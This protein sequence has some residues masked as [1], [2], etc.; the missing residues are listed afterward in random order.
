MAVLAVAGLASPAVA[1]QPA[2]LQEFYSQPLS[3]APCAEEG[4]LA[5]LQCATLV[6]PMNYRKPDAERISVTISKLPAKDPAKRRGVLLINPGGPGGPG[7]DMPLVFA[8]RPIAQ[9]YDMIGFDPRGVGRST[10]LRC[11]V[12]PAIADFPSRPTDAEFELYTAQARNDE[13]ACE[14]AAGGLR[15]Y[16]NTPNTARDM[17]VIRGALGEKKINYLG[18]SYGTY[19]G[20]VFGSLFPASLDRNV[21]DSSVSPDWI[22]REQFKQQAVAMRENVDAF[23]TWVGERNSVY[24]LGKSYA[25]VFA[26]TEALAAKLATKPINDP[27]FGEVDRT[28]YDAIVGANARYRPLWDA[29]AQVIKAFK[30][31]SDG[32]LAPGSAELADAA[33]AAK[34]MKDLAIAETVNGVFQTVTCEADWPGD[35]SIYYND[36]KL[37]REKYPYGFGVYR[38]APTECTFRSFKP[39]DKVT[40]LKRAGYPTGLVIQADG[41]SQ[42]HYDGGP[43]MAAKLRDQLVSVADDG[44]HSLYS[45]NACA[46]DIIDKYLV[47]GVL[48]GTRVTCPGDPRPNVPADGEQSGQRPANAAGVA[49]TVQQY[50]SAKRLG[51]GVY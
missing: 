30:A 46:S 3:W 12:S 10:P 8:D 18:F 39:A 16:V 11:E 41:D 38:A 34:L 35:L 28:I 44:T 4:E 50:I 5:T 25:E 45:R 36:M 37:F 27:D 9:V 17:D 7:V 29:L 49:D 20:A 32:T 14:R 23:Y 21:L 1:A 40:D 33:K 19:L 47:D 48:P 24:G 26:T 42:T 2:A 6:V 22:W 51:K 13:A 15:P 31:A 43:A